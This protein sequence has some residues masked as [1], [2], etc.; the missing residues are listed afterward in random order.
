MRISDWSSDVC[1][2]DLEPAPAEATGERVWEGG[3]MTPHPR[4]ALQQNRCYARPDFAAGAFS[5][6]GHIREA[7]PL[8][9]DRKRVVEGKSVSV[10]VDLGVSRDSK[11][12]K[13]VII[14]TCKE[15][16]RTERQ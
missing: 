9:I 7:I 5:D 14:Y 11:K 3:R 12:T 15:E 2:S 4:L 16:Q 8:G 13:K 1:S 6:A 10:R